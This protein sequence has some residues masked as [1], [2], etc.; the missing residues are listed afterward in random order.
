MKDGL[1][2]LVLM[3]S[4]VFVVSC[5]EQLPDGDLYAD[6]YTPS[7]KLS[8]HEYV[9]LG[10]SV[11]WAKCNLGASTATEI[12][13]FYAWGEIEPKVSYT[14][15]NYQWWNGSSA[16]ITK[17]CTIDSLAYAGIADGLT[18]LQLQ[19]DAA[20]VQKGAPWRMPTSTECEELIKGCT[21]H[22]V[23]QNGQVGFEGIS[24]V[25]GNTIFLP[26]AGFRAHENIVYEYIGGY[27]SSTLNTQKQHCALGIYLN[28]KTTGVGPYFNSN[29]QNGFLI[30]PVFSHLL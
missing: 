24:K 10:L 22:L 26:V 21:W 28:V 29:R 11:K 8:G 13:D 30:R 17:Y 16:N 3:L 6:K 15:N 4:V 2:K 5:E 25:N 18:E 20:Y 1:L 23:N 27:W 9:D 12:G 14:F 7:G 19:D